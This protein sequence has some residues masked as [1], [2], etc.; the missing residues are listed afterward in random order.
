MKNYTKQILIA[1]A[2]LGGFSTTTYAQQL[3]EKDLKVNINQIENSV[4][5]LKQ[6]QPITYSYNTAKFKNLNLPK[7]EQY[8][9]ATQNIEEVSPAL[10]QDAAHVYSVSK[11]STK[12]ANFK[13]VDTA[14]LIP[15]LV[16]AIQEQQQQIDALKLALEELKAK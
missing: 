9:F 15:M 8:G 14:K 6:L 7:G 11:N 10:I 13:E 16:T 12:T 2:L 4:S 3:H 5:L 1:L